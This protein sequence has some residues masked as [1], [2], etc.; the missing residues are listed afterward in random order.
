MGTL[1]SYASVLTAMPQASRSD[2]T[3][4]LA[5]KRSRP[6]YSAHSPFSVPSLFMI[7]TNSSPCFLPS[8]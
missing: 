6:A 2:H 7:L 1:V 8:A 5:L 4:S 3:L